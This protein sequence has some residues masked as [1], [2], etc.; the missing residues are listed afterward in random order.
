MNS[1]EQIA[2][3]LAAQFTNTV[4]C[5]AVQASLHP[6]ATWMQK[7]ET[8]HFLYDAPVI[9]MAVDGI[10]AMDDARMEL[11]LGLIEE[12]FNELKV[13]VKDRDIVEMADALADI[14]YVV[15]G[16]ALE[17]GID[18]NAVFNEV[19]AS[20]MTKMG[21]DGEPVK[22]EDGKILKGPNYIKPDVRKVLFG[23]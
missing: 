2:F 14:A 20:N 3:D 6:S 8:F 10:P 18:L 4:K 21:G 7:V 16:F 1:L 5:D 19:H 15:C 11:R 12:E 23:A 13:A 22:R 9:L 17:A